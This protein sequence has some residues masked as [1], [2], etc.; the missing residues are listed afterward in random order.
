MKRFLKIVGIAAGSIVLLV[1]LAI[2][3]MFMFCPRSR[4]VSAE[5]IEQTPE[6]VARGR[7]LAQHVSPCIECHSERLT[8]RYTMPIRPGTEGSGGLDFSEGDFRLFSANITPDAETGIGKWSDDEVLRAM[9]EGV[10]KDGEPIFPSM[11]YQLFRE[12]SDDDA[13]AIVAY[14]RTLPA[15]R[16][17]VPK[18][19][20]PFPM[21]VIMRSIPKPLEHP[22]P[23]VE[24]TNTVAYG[25]YLS[26]ISGCVFCHSPKDDHMQNIEGR[27]FSGGFEMKHATGRVVTANITPDPNTF[28][29][30]SSRAEFIA[31]FK[32]MQ[33]MNASNAPVAPKGRNTIMPWLAYSGMTEEDLGAIYDYLRTVKPVANVVNSF[34][35]AQ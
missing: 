30:R 17:A 22:V 5:K 7:Y 4:P 11:P 21:N 16:K 6:R 31:H 15:V 2:G 29:G 12:M 9:R 25:K 35:D 27:E 34:P 32:A 24:R 20:I 26:T 19:E 28:V 23:A 13:R 3:A 18:R 8:D 14:L 33:S 1:A 10:R